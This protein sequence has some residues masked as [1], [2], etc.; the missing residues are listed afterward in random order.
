MKVPASSAGLDVQAYPLLLLLRKNFILTSPVVVDRASSGS[1][2]M[3]N[4]PEED[5][6][7]FAAEDK[8]TLLLMRIVD[9][10]NDRNFEHLRV[11]RKRATSLMR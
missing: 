9:H 5:P 7:E 1:G 11:S 3:E 4:Y 8:L 6:I 2:A 10:N